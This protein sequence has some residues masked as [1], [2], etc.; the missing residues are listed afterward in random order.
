MQHQF[1]DE[2]L[3]Q[4]KIACR[5]LRLPLHDTIPFSPKS[6]AAASGDPAIK[7]M[8][9][10][11]DDK[12]ERLQY[13]PEGQSSKEATLQSVGITALPMNQTNKLSSKELNTLHSTQY[14]KISKPISIHNLPSHKSFEQLTPTKAHAKL[15][16]SGTQ[17]SI[18]LHQEYEKDMDN[19]TNPD[20]AERHK[21]NLNLGYPMAVYTNNM[22][23]CAVQ[24]TSRVN[25]DDENKYVGN[26]ENHHVYTIAPSTEG[27]GHNSARSNLGDA[28][29]SCSSNRITCPQHNAANTSTLHISKDE[30]NFSDN[31]ANQTH[32]HKRRLAKK[33]CFSS[34]SESDEEPLSILHSNRATAAA[35]CRLQR[36]DGKRARFQCPTSETEDTTDNDYSTNFPN[37]TNS[38]TSPTKYRHLKIQEDCFGKQHLPIHPFLCS[39][40][41]LILQI[42][43]HVLIFV[44]W[45]CLMFYKI[46][47]FIASC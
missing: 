21:E 33:G 35:F 28:F 6:T 30:Y 3:D 17:Y 38:V 24:A 9:N 22:F 39:Y 25:H 31:P 46:A 43:V 19:G 18:D 44:F 2:N 37:L 34:S 32:L 41:T 8:H 11:I 23:S 47:N 5:S 42:V 40:K 26:G 16:T 27:K 29:Y 7:H 20:V 45:I 1:P 10:T 12:H 13:W 36:H 4:Q 15:T 14:S